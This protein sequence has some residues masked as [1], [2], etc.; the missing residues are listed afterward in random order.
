MFN[1]NP[2]I[3]KT[4]LNIIYNILFFCELLLI[5]LPLVLSTN[6]KL[7]LKSLR[8]TELEKHLQLTRI[9]LTK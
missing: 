4:I 9:K 6:N 3:I 1:N 8:T 5:A 7:I 2:Y